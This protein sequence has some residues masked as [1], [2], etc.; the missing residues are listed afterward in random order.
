M[1]IVLDN[2]DSHTNKIT[3]YSDNWFKLKNKVIHSNLVISKNYLYE[4]FLTDNFQDFTLN[5][6]EKIITWGPEII[7]I[8]SG[9]V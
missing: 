3:A 2:E 8:G 4:D 7:L 6:L 5:H 1:Q 9:K